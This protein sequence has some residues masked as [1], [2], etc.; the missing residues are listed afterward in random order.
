MFMCARAM[1]GPSSSMVPMPDV[2]SNDIGENHLICLEY[3][4]RDGFDYIIAGGV[5]WS[6]SQAG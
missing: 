4:F 6:K 1:G 5:T 2:V 3:E